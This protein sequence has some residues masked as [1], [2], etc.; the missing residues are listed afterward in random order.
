MSS[1]PAPTHDSSAILDQFYADPDRVLHQLSQLNELERLRHFQ[2]ILVSVHG[3]VQP[4]LAAV[5]DLASKQ[6][7]IDA[8][9]R[10]TNAQST[11]FRQ[12]VNVH[13]LEDVRQAQR[14]LSEA[15]TEKNISNILR[16]IQ[17]RWPNFSHEQIPLNWV[18]ESQR[19]AEPSRRLSS[20]A[21][22]ALAAVALAGHTWEQFRMAADTWLQQPD[23]RKW[24][25][26]TAIRAI[27]E[28]LPLGRQQSL[29][30]R[31]QSTPMRRGDSQ[32]STFTRISCHNVRI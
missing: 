9:V 31:Q 27:A 10:W 28:V 15:T 2:P 7:A 21:W 18:K 13:Q 8:L 20:D 24:I 19:A 22:E 30:A 3:A 25:T 11:T 1:G 14:L 12:L 4:L 17:S 16:R 5:N 26:K 29:P 6:R 23:S 32:V